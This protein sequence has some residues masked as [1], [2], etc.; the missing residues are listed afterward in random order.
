MHVGNTGQLA[1]HRKKKNFFEEI[2]LPL[3]MQFYFEKLAQV[4]AE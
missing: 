3:G 1:L 4:R 2:K